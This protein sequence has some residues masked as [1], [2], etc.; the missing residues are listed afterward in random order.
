M[1]E[2]AGGFAWDLL[3][4]ESQVTGPFGVYR[5]IAAFP[6]RPEPRWAIVALRDPTDGFRPRV[7]CPDGPRVREHRYSDRELCLYYP[8][9]PPERRWTLDQGLLGLFDMARAHVHAEYSLLMNPE[10]GWPL[11]EAPHGPTA[12]APSDPALRLPP[13]AERL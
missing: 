13:L 10:L 8:K 12:P 1:Y 4:W 3:A 7:F 6:G 11:P 9:D 2:K 5:L